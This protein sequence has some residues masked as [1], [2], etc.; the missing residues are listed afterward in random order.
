MRTFTPMISWHYGEGDTPMPVLGADFHAPAAAGGLAGWRLATCGADNTVKM[1]LAVQSDDRLR[2]LFLSDLKRHQ[3]TVNCVRFSPNGTALHAAPCCL[4]SFI[5]FL[6]FSFFLL[7]G[8]GQWLASA[9]DDA[10]IILWALKAGAGPAGNLDGEAEELE[11]WSMAAT[12][13]GHTEDVLDLAWSP[14]SRHLLSGSV[15]NTAI[16]WDTQTGTGR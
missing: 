9:G 2:M 12:L 5:L 8:A 10:T 3:R 1:W 14:D 7:R 4:C 16:V 6:C 13:K 15:D 11:H